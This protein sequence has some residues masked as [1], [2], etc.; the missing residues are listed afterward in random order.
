MNEMQITQLNL[1]EVIRILGVYI[2]LSLTWNK[3]FEVIANKMKESIAKLNNTKM[4][5]NMIYMYFNAY[6]MKSVYFG[7]G[8]IVLNKLQDNILRKMCEP[9]IV[10]SQDQEKYS[11]ERFYM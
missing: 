6:L 2:Y 4:H 3:Q 8:I 7:C 9:I 5:L 11:R 10:K 1:T